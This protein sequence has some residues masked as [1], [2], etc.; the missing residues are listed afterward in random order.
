M[1]TLS[2]NGIETP[3]FPIIKIY[4]IFKICLKNNQFI[5]LPDGSYGNMI[6]TQT[7][8]IPYLKKTCLT[9]VSK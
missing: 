2:G 7:P 8:I 4:V 5:N 3:N 6:L 9:A 1:M